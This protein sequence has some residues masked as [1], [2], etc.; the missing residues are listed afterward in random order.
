[1]V[2][3]CARLDGLPLA[4]ELAA[5]RLRSLSLGA[6]H[7]RL[8]Q[9][10]RLLPGEAAPPRSGSRPCRRRSAGPIRCLAAP[11]SS[12]WGACR[13]SPKASTWTPPKRSAA[14][15]TS[16][17]STSPPCSARWWTRAWSWPSRPGQPCATGCWRPSASSPP[18]GG[19]RCALP[20]G[21]R[22][23]GPVSDRARPGQ[24]ARPAGCRPG[25]PAARR[26][27]RGQ[28]SGWDRTGPAVRRRPAPLLGGA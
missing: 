28:P 4:I 23:G 10:F 22:D 18:G 27:A 21:R 14:S 16:R 6:L 5:A 25:E 12:C 19:A 3:I 15:G 20:V 8:D 26:R 17:R 13:Y 24:L 11:N 2:S 1:M 7:D 9:R